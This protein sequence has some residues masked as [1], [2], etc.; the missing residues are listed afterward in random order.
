MKCTAEV[1]VV[2]F[3]AHLKPYPNE[4]CVCC[5]TVGLTLDG[6]GLHYDNYITIFVHYLLFPGQI[7]YTQILEFEV[8]KIM[9]C[10]NT[11]FT[12]HN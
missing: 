10:Q 4:H 12:M 7:C 6:H 5:K 11:N 2:S 3:A 8:N 9:C 1:I